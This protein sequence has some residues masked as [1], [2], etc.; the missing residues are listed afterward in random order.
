MSTSE[1]ISTGILMGIIHVL[2][3]PDH[4]SALATLCG[5][6]IKSQSQSHSSSEAFFLGVRWG[7]GHSFGLLIVGGLLI[8]MEESSGEWIGMDPVLSTVFESF[9]GIF[10]LALGAYGLFKAEK[11]NR[12]STVYQVDFDRPGALAAS[13]NDESYRS[14]G[15][16]QRY[17]IPEGFP[18]SGD[19]A[20]AMEDVLDTDSRCSASIFDLCDD[21]SL[22][23]DDYLK[24]CMES[25]GGPSDMSMVTISMKPLPSK[26][27]S[28]LRRATSLMHEHTSSRSLGVKHRLESLCCG[29]GQRFFGSS[30][31]IMALVAGV[32]HGVAGP[33]GVLGVIP[34]VQL[35]DARLAVLY[36]GTF[37]FTSTLVMGGFA[38]FYGQLSEWL[39][40]GGRGEMGNRV[41]MVE[42]GSALLSVCVGCVWLVLLTLGKLDDVFP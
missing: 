5:T 14:D 16:I 39:A 34:A 36:L 20:A 15:G 37:C 7:L 24:D 13:L 9:V 40:G 28:N 31:G 27:P 19:I 4:L 8:A 18:G 25:T 10:M 22:S 30:P 21:M 32:I 6:N 1:L 23:A 3:G 11:N 33:G 12:E 38:A 41:F 26:P 29:I 2:T 17:I 42:I 35:K